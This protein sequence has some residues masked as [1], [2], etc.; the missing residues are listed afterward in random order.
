M[1]CGRGVTRYVQAN[2]TVDPLVSAD[3]TGFTNTRGIGGN[4]DVGLEFNT[5]GEE[6][7]VLQT[8]ATDATSQGTWLDQGTSDQ[9]WVE[10]LYSSG[11]ASQ[12]VGFSNSTRY[13]LDVTRK[14]YISDTSTGPGTL[15]I[16]GQFRFWDAAS[17]GS[18]LD[19]TTA[20]Q[21]LIADYEEICPMCCFTPDTLITMANGIQAPIIS[22]REGD[23][24]AVQGG[25][26]A[27]TEVIT[28]MNRVMY[29]V[30]FADGRNLRMSD[31]HPLYV[32]GK[33]YAAFNPVGDYKD[34]GMAKV[35]KLGDKVLD[36]HGRLNK[37]VDVQLIDYPQTV[38]TFGNSKFYANGMLVY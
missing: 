20:S 21:T 12:W 38:Y 3:G 33:G 6:Y 4:C 2:A 1:L 25:S 18:T 17:G 29:N 32:Y 22:I 14:F 34:L 28:Q 23:M 11:S 27:V 35:L 8:G 24:I 15:S 7:R 9:V 10:F 13:Q 37:I 5:D 30:K 19:T 36:E 16:T 26:E 31:D